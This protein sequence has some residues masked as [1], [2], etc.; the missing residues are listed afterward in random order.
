MMLS[1]QVV[2]KP[3]AVRLLCLNLRWC[4]RG[5][6]HV[7]KATISIAA[8]EWLRLCADGVH[9]LMP[10][11]V[12]YVQL[13]GCASEVRFGCGGGYAANV[14]LCADGARL[15]MLVCVD[16]VQLAALSSCLITCAQSSSINSRIERFCEYGAMPNWSFIRCG[17]LSHGVWMEK[18]SLVFNVWNAYA[19]VA[20]RLGWF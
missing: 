4:R 2:W 20:I 12:G 16:D 7:R 14:S 8:R 19:S 10:V 6:L 5:M 9:L 1:W 17:G 15:L 18:W 11:C 3:M 13:V